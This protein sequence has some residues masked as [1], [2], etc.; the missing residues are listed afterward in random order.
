ME[1]ENVTTGVGQVRKELE[2][3]IEIDSKYIEQ[4]LLGFVTTCTC[5]K[6]SDFVSL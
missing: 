4:T 6:K 1:D 5:T 2:E 3:I